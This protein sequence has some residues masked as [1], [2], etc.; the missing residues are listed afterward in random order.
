VGNSGEAGQFDCVN[1]RAP[2]Y[3]TF[4]ETSGDCAGKFTTDLVDKPGINTEVVCYDIVFPFFTVDPATID[5]DNP[6][7]TATIEGSGM[8]SDGGLPV[9]EYYDMNGT[10]VAQQTASDLS[11][12]GTLLSMSLPDLSA[13]AGGRYLITVRN[14]DGTVAGD[15]VVD[16]FHYSSVPSDP[17]PGDDPPGCQQDCEIY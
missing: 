10:L 1:C 6:P 8:S 2:G 16:L 4:G 14:A 17:G 12:D 5:L 13:V 7:T 15:G 11:A 9:V 3:W